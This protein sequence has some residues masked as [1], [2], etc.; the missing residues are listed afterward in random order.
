MEKDAKES[1][2][3]G[4]VIS[5]KGSGVPKELEGKFFRVE[6]FEADGSVRL[7]KPYSDQACT[8][9]YYSKAV[10]A[11]REDYRRLRGRYPP[12]QD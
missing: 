11:Y 8:V 12:E 10:N 9:R 3:V 5:V 6:G 7:S 1:Y 4:D 2:A